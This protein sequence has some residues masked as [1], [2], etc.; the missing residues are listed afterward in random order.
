MLCVLIGIA[1]VKSKKKFQV[2][3]CNCELQYQAFFQMPSEN[4]PVK[5]EL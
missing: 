5:F 3:Q 4:F 2:T 1:E